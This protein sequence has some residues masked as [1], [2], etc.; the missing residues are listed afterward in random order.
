MRYFLDTNSL[1]NLVI[2]QA[3]NRGD[4]YILQDVLEE[5]SN[6]TVET[7][8]IERSGINIVDLSAKHLEKMKKVLSE[9]GH[10]TGLI[11]LSSGEGK[12]DVSMLAYILSEKE[13]PDSLFAVGDYSIITKDKTLAEVAQ[14]YG[15]GC[16]DELP[17]P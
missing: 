8:R 1:T 9:H 11:D 14:N 2:N 6:S 4:I 15:I 10:N 3:R 12:A 17:L 7:S 13:N 5:F 16:L